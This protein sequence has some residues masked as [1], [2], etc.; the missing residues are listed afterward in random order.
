MDKIIAKENFRA[1]NEEMANKYNPDTFHKKSNFI[2]RHIEG[3]RIRNIIKELGLQENDR[4]LEVGCGAGNIMEKIPRG[5]ITGVDLSEFL[6]KIARN[7]A[8]RHK[9]FVA[10][11]Q[12]LPFK[13]GT[14]NKVICSEV[15]EHVL[16]PESVL[17][18]TSRVLTNNGT[19]I[20]TI[21]H[22]KSINAVKKILI[23][24]RLFKLLDSKY[25]Y[26]VSRNMQDE[27]HIHS[28]RIKDFTRILANYYKIC[29]V[30][31]SPSIFLAL[32]Y[33]IKASK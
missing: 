30:Y 14:F 11:A 28:F 32:R 1:W 18:E 20:I 7:K 22:E 29:K 2:I 3:L 19:A 25:G 8:A 33:I 24:L 16:S 15:L 21:P 6:V 23:R 27:W 13:D 10:D 31:P 17:K 4:I 12:A 5:H 9:V 26:K